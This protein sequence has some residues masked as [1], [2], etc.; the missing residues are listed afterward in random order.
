MLKGGKEELFGTLH[1]K[2]TELRKAQTYK[3]VNVL[4]LTRCF[5]HS[6]ISL[7]IDVSD[8]DIL[9]E[10]I[11]T[12]ILKMDGAWDIRTIHLLNPHFFKLPDNVD[13]K[14]YGHFTITLDVRS[15]ATDVVLR[16]IRNLAS[17]DEAAISFL[18]YSFYSY[19]NDIIMSLLAPDI[20]SAGKFV[21]EKIR[22]IDGLID[23]FLWQISKWKFVIN[24]KDWFKYIN[25]S[26]LSEDVDFENWDDNY[27]DL[28]ASFICAC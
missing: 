8:P 23:T 24:E 28:A 18:A 2:L 25:Y 10:F 27:T 4:Y 9:P 17:S 14:S 16:Q 5:T 7:I 3:N 12:E 22:S 15:D 1:N 19:D 13:Y 26:R 20:K 11:T 6:D 21:D